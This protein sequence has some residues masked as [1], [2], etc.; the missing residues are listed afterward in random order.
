M[1][2]RS[3]LSTRRS[4]LSSAG[5]K[6]QQ[7]AHSRAPPYVRLSSSTVWM[8]WTLSMAEGPSGT[9]AAHM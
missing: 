9:L 8:L 1:C 2:V 3:A 7:V 4:G 5:V 6:R